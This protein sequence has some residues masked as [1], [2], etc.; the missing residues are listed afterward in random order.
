M[1]KSIQTIAEGLI[2]KIHQFFKRFL[3]TNAIMELL[4]GGMSKD[5]EYVTYHIRPKKACDIKTVSFGDERV[6]KF[7]IVMQ[8]PL[9]E[10]DAFTE[11]SLK[12]YKQ[13]FPRALLILSTWHGVPNDILK[14]IGDLGIRVVLNERPEYSGESSINLQIVS[15]INGIR[16]AK[17]L[18]AEYAIKTRT[19]QRMYSPDI[20]TYLRNL[21]DIFPVSRLYPKQK[22]RLIG[23]SLNTFKNRLYGLSDMFMCG[24][25]DDMEMYWSVD[26]DKRVFDDEQ[27]R[28]ASTSLRRYAQLKIC[29]IYLATFYLGKIGRDLE[30]T[31]KDSLK[32]FGEHFCIVDAE[33]LDLYWPK[34]SHQEFRRK[35]YAGN[36]RLTEIKFR[37]WIGVYKSIENCLINESILDE[38]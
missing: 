7:A 23:C 20:L 3:S 38:G 31:L 12:I 35:S 13:H 6:E 37:D 21:I 26:L 8:G 18:G 9:I 30:W 5:Q 10:R 34:Y 32:V 1:R 27:R 24:H 29:E 25:I 2:S 17:A 11:E 14:R 16:L 22:Y 19:D 4:C 15:S 33:Q 36:H 28:H